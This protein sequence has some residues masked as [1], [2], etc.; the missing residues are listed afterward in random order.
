MQLPA[1]IPFSKVLDA[2]QDVETP[3]NPR[4]LYRLSDLEAAELEQLQIAWPKIPAWRRVALLEDIEELN[5]SDMLLSFESLGRFALQDKEAKVRLLAVRILWEF[6]E[7][8]LIPVFSRLMTTDSDSEVRAAAASALGRF[9]YVGELEEIPQ[10]T[11]KGIEEALLAAATGS[12]APEVRRCALESLG[13][14]SR[15]EV[16]PLIEKAFASDDK[17]WKASALFAMGRSANQQWAPTVLAMLQSNLPLLRSEAAR[18]AG[19]LEIAEAVP[20]LFELLDDPDD[21]TR[22]AS[23]WSLSQI[24]GEGV[25]ETLESLYDE[26]DNE[27]ELELLESALDNLTFNEGLQLIPMFDF[28]EAEDDE[29]WYEEYDLE[30]MDEIFED[31]EEDDEG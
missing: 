15:D 27:Q 17:H 4:Y 14:S 13:Y 24:G 12:D 11:L 29:D 7:T 25:R 31:E 18:A 22:Q 16:T 3:L 21:N 19:E 1:E 6:E 20:Q 23:I 30:D 9:V 28:P 8:S 10:R 26:S 5:E 2:L